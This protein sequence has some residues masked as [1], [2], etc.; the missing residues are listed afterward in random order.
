[1]AD[2]PECLACGACC[3]SR[4]E[5]FVRV[6]GDDY[7]RLGERA[8]TL[9]R[10]DGFRG[11]MRMTD[12]HC[13]ALVLDVTSERWMCGAYATRPQVCRDLARSS[14]QCLAELDAKA[15]RPLVALRQAR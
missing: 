8:E 12:G 6:T 2:V 1:V 14:G 15:E 7:E 11:H 4:L 13:S 9:V 5:T 10:F 3:F